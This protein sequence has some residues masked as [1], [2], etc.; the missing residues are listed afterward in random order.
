MRIVALFRQLHLAVA[1]G[2]AA[3]LFFGAL[4]VA[5]RTA[6]A[7]DVLRGGLLLLADRFATGATELIASGLQAVADRDALIEDEAL[8][9]PS[10]LAGRDRFEIFENASLQVIH[11]IEASHSHEGGGFLAANTASAEHRHFRFRA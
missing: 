11:L 2:E 9:L 3:F 8:T 6:H 5:F 4:F 1:F 7:G 10:V